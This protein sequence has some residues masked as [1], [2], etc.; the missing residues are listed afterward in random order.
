[1]YPAYC[2]PASPTYQQWVRLSV[3]DFHDLWT[4][5]E[6]QSQGIFFKQ[7]YPVEFVRIVAPIVAIE[8]FADRYTV[9]TLDDGSGDTVNVRITRRSLH[10]TI[11]EP[12]PWNTTAETNIDVTTSLGTLSVHIDGVA[13]EIGMIIKAK[14]TISVFRDTKQL[15]LIRAD[16]LHGPDEETKAWEQLAQSRE[17]LSNPWSLSEERIQELRDEHER[18]KHLEQERAEAKAKRTRE[19]KVKKKILQEKQA[20]KH[21]Q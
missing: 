1:I 13:L 16:V 17:L 2:H 20:K 3:L 15:D 14:G 6:F 10:D 7:N 11:T 4:N 9:L 19:R 12:R 5:S 8:D 18:K 21:A